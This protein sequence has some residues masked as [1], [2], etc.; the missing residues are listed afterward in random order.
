MKAMTSNYLSVHIFYNVADLRA[1]LLEC[2]EPLVRRLESKGMIERYF[3]IRY[4]EGGA[5][6]RLRLLPSAH[7]SHD[8]LKAEVDP[9]IERFLEDRPSLFDPD[10][11]VMAPL[12]RRLYVME[13]GEQE[14]E[15]RF[16]ATG[17]IPLRPNNSF[18]YIPYVPEYARYGGI[19]GMEVSERHFH[20]SSNIAFD[21]LRDS[22]SSVRTST[23]G[24]AFQMMLHFCY[25]FFEDRDMVIAFFRRYGEF[26]Q[27]VNVPP[28]LQAG[29][30]RVFERQA[31]GIVEQT[32]QLEAINQRLRTGEMGALSKYVIDARHVRGE[33]DRLYQTGQLE[34]QGPVDSF[35]HVANRLLT[36]YV[37]MTNNR[38][39]LLIIEE[40][41]MA[42]MIVRALEGDL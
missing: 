11:E 4:W 27:G 30:D 33:V 40:V 10:P 8:E 35:E 13:Y 2:V 23:L 22:N 15:E 29:F 26:F 34:F 38:L 1:I 24:M 39:G 12:M 17:L 31:Q 3:V 5:H 18:A 16:G 20:T 14:Y 9:A 7:V 25:A 21:A 41:Y 19:Q 42:N 6:V 32:Q 37:H 28:D 36:S